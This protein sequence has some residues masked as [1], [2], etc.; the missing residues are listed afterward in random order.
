MNIETTVLLCPRNDEESLQ[1]LKIAKAGGIDVL[2]SE[3]PHGARLEKEEDLLGRLRQ[4]NPN[5][6]HVVIVEIPGPDV[7]RQLKEEGV[8]VTIIDHHQYD[9]LDRSSPKSSL[10]QFLETFH[11]S[12]EQ[13]TQHGFDP[14]MVKSVAAMDRGFVWELKKMVADPGTY[15]EALAYYRALTLELGA[16]RRLLEEEVAQATWEG[17]AE[18]NGYVFVESEREDVSFRDA[19]SFLVAQEFDAPQP[20]IIK[21][22]S[23]RLYV[24][25]C[26]Q[27]TDLYEQFGGFLFG[28]NK[29]WG[30]LATPKKPLPSLEDV[31]AVLK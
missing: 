21:Q 2:V 10:E 27:A 29:C 26:E 6:D 30:V 31:L 14:V 28:Q 15:K 3:Q 24:Q 13:L 12:D 4:V 16:D 17:R 20:V 5:V 1:I 8:K 22:G 7:E 23:R 25:D 11:I 18:R 9:G 19:L